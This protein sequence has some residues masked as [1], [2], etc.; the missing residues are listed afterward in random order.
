MH[1]KIGRLF[2]FSKFS[3]GHQKEGRSHKLVK[4][5]KISSA[6]PLFQ[7]PTSLTKTQRS[8]P[9]FRKIKFIQFFKTKQFRKVKKMCVTYAYPIKG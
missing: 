8:Q 2:E 6:L 4:I 3:L 9:N 1:H 5:K 7:N